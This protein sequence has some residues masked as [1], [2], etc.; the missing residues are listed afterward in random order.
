VTGPP[1]R[2]PPPAVAN[3]LAAGAPADA[4]QPDAYTPAPRSEA[5]ES[6]LAAVERGFEEE[7]DFLRRLV[8][9]PSTRGETNGA[10]R[11]VAAELSRTGLAVQEVGIDREAIARLPGYSPAEWSYEGLVQVLGTLPGVLTTPRAPG[12]PEPPGRRA[13]ARSSSTATWTSS[14]RSRAPTGATTPGGRRW[15]TG[16]STGGAPAT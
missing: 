15:Q 13:G 2:E 12:A 8:R 11:V 6:V 14:V 16:A 10:Q 4:P 1:A 3:P 5:K 7:V 9:C